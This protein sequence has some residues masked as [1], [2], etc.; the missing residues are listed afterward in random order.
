MKIQYY[1]DG[2]STPA[3][4]TTKIVLIEI[5]VLCTCYCNMK[6]KKQSL[7]LQYLWYISIDISLKNFLTGSNWNNL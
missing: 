7:F 2:E 4:T 5:N 3:T 1:I 6:K